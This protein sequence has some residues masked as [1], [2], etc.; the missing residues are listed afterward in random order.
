MIVVFTPIM[1][2][3][4]DGSARPITLRCLTQ[5]LIQG[6]AKGGSSSVNR[7]SIAASEKQCKGKFSRKS[8]PFCSF[9]H[10]H[11]M[12]PFLFGHRNHAQP[13]RSMSFPMV[14]V[15]RR[16]GASSGTIAQTAVLIELRRQARN[17]G[18][19]VRPV[20]PDVAGIVPVRGLTDCPLH[21]SLAAGWLCSS[22]GRMVHDE[23]FQQ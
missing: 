23:A 7:V 2:I 11:G 10:T 6:P 22:A 4:K 5:S 15:F 8:A 1:F 20:R 19:C 14:R 16:R 21:A 3:R 18:Q 12:A 13:L 17:N 9:R